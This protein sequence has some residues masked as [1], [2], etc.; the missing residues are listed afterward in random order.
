[1]RILERRRLVIGYNCQMGPY[2]VACILVWSLYV[3]LFV[4][5]TSDFIFVLIQSLIALFICK[6][7]PGF[8]SSL[9][10]VLILSNLLIYLLIHLFIS[11]KNCLLSLFILSLYIYMYYLCQNSLMYI[12]H[13]KV[14]FPYILFILNYYTYYYFEIFI[15]LLFQIILYITRIFKIPYILFYTILYINC[16][17]FLCHL[18]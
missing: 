7:A 5:L 8:C 16:F 3:Y 13:F 9:N 14:L 1:M 17:K 6:S 4:F 11:K 10:L 2:D 18:F 15:Y 12:F